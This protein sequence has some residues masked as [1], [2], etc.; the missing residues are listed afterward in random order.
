MA[1]RRVA[2]MILFANGSIAA[3]DEHEQQITELQ[4]WSAI[5][6]FARHAAASG[7]DV[8]GCR[9][10]TQ[11]LGYEGVIEATF[12]GFSERVRER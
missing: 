7:F 11:C 3:F 8:D 1:K 5:E 10:A 4:T 2:A 6:L 9:F 12:D